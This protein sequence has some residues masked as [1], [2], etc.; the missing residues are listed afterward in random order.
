MKSITKVNA[1]AYQNAP[2][3]IYRCQGPSHDMADPL[4]YHPSQ[5]YLCAD[6]AQNG[7]GRMID[8]S[9][10]AA[11][12]SSPVQVTNPSA[13]TPEPLAWLDA[14]IAEQRRIMASYGYSPEMLSDAAEF[15]ERYATEA[16]L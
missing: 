5:F 1:V 11:T 4:G 15:E 6:A 3:I 10:I 16:E 9:N 12:P 13:E 7:S 8:Q 2:Y 14:I